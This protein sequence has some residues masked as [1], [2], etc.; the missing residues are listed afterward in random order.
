MS[1][2]FLY[3]KR[4]RTL[5][6]PKYDEEPPP[7][8][9]SIFMNKY[10]PV[11]LLNGWITCDTLGCYN[12]PSVNFGP[13]T[14]SGEYTT[15]ASS[16][17]E[18]KILVR[19]PQ[20]EYLFNSNGDFYIDNDAGAGSHFAV[21]VNS[22]DGGCN[23]EHMDLIT[24]GNQF[25]FVN[26]VSLSAGSTVTFNGASGVCPYTR[27]D[28]YTD[29]NLYTFP[30]DIALS[31]GSTIAFTGG[32]GLHIPIP[33]P[34]VGLISV[35]RMDMCPLQYYSFNDFMFVP[36]ETQSLDVTNAA[37]SYPA[38]MIVVEVFPDAIYFRFHRNDCDPNPISLELSIGRQYALFGLIQHD[39]MPDDLYVAILGVSS[40][41]GTFVHTTAVVRHEDVNLPETVI[42]FG[43]NVVQLVYEPSQ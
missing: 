11:A 43:T 8:T 32:A 21:N 14:E 35:A 38:Y 6:R 33:V 20:R 12:V 22:G 1:N 3:S 37:N 7:L 19:I 36:P 25:V 34:L 15:G 4:K 23:Y 31:A 9:Y 5:N 17:G 18:S 10:L 39:D 42:C 16:N 41:S 2:P 24:D 26:N 29:Q 40:N 30:H 28:L 13:Y 27:Q